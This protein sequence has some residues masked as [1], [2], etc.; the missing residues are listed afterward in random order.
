MLAITSITFADV[1]SRLLRLPWWLLLSLVVLSF[2]FC[3]LSSTS[4]CCSFGVDGCR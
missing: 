3:L 2:L 4:N 1:E